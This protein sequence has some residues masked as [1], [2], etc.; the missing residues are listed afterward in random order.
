MYNFNQGTSVLGTHHRNM[1]LKINLPASTTAVDFE[2]EANNEPY[3]LLNEDAL[4]YTTG[5]DG[6]ASYISIVPMIAPPPLAVATTA[7]LNIY[8][9]S[10]VGGDADFQIHRLLASVSLARPAIN[11]ST[12]I[13]GTTYYFFTTGTQESGVGSAFVYSGGPPSFPPSTGQ[14]PLHLI[15]DIMDCTSVV[16]ELVCNIASTEYGI[17]YNTF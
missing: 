7:T 6:L 14:P 8:G 10:G 1:R 2:T 16:T 17:A 12:L 13:K 5:D 15:V 11:H 9:L 4:I 3:G